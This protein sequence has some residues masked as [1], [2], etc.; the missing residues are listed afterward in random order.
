VHM[1]DSHTH[2][3]HSH[4]THNHAHRGSFCLL[5]VQGGG[6][7]YIQSFSSCEKERWHTWVYHTIYISVCEIYLYVDILFIV[8]SIV[9][10]LNLKNLK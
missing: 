5:Q 6:V 1:W 3:S 4:F 8:C 9:C 10:M 7:I 2:N